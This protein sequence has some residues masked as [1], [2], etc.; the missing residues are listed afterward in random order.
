MT[1]FA[2]CVQV[3]KHV[4]AILRTKRQLP[5]AIEAQR[6]ETREDK[7]MQRRLSISR[8]ASVTIAAPADGNTSARG[9][10]M[11]FLH[12]Q[13]PFATATVVTCV[14]MYVVQALS[15]YKL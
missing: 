3:S 15:L 14:C 1:L 4:T 5:G 10:L 12:V 8:G 11:L 7:V 13:V 6:F 2:L 9:Q